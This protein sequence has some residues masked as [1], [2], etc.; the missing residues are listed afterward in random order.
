MK[1]VIIDPEKCIG[2]KHCYL[3]CAVEHASDKNLLGAIA[4]EPV[5]KARI[6]VDIGLDQRTFPN[7]CRHCDPAPCVDACP[8]GA[9]FRD[10]RT[11]SVLIDETRCINCAMCAMACPFGVIRFHPEAQLPFHT[12]VAVKCD[13][14]VERQRTH[15]PPAC[16]EACKTGALSFEALNEALQIRH[17][18]AIR[19][20]KP[21][22]EIQAWRKFN[23][24][25]ASLRDETPTPESP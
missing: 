11:A 2:C 16:V 9:M 14:C 4:Q 18:V 21:P 10:E 19:Q 7:R 8:S 17:L 23:T 22:R 1:S 13:N 3:A 15:K 6:F 25:V 12:T 5:P 24:A 20:E